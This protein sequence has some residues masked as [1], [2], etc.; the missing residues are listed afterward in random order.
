MINGD[1]GN[2]AVRPGVLEV[3]KGFRAGEFQALA[4]DTLVTVFQLKGVAFKRQRQPGGKGYRQVA[5]HIA[6]KLL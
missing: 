1:T 6:D 3:G 2:Q 4:A 5:R